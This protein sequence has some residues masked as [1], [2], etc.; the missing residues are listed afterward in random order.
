MKDKGRFLSFWHQID[1]IMCLK[2]KRVL[3]IGIGAGI[4]SHYLK[5]IINVV[6]VDI[7]IDNKPD[8]IA[9]IRMLPFK[10]NSFDVIASFEVLEHMPF[11]DFSPTLLKISRLSKYLILSLPDAYYCMRIYMMLPLLGI[12]NMLISGTKSKDKLIKNKNIKNTHFWEIG[13][14][15]TTLNKVIRQIQISGWG[16]QKTYRNFDKPYHRFF[17]C[18]RKRGNDEA[19]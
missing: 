18:K 5:K 8:V 15:D 3:E 2:P 17:V 19:R 9:D 12:F 1:E 13:R 7:N 16:I 6:T 11:E 14:G 10:N 4:T